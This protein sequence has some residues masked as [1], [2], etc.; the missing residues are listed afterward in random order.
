[1]MNFYF[2]YF[3]ACGLLNL[4]WDILPISL[5]LSMQHANFKKLSRPTNSRSQAKKESVLTMNQKEIINQTSN[6]DYVL[7][8]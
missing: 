2:E 3:L 6:S 5:I 1:M 7:E 4:L 8:S